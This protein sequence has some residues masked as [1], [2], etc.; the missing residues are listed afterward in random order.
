MA[1]SRYEH[2]Q[3]MHLRILSAYS[4][5]PGASFILLIPR[6]LFRRFFDLL[7][8]QTAVV[9]ILVARCSFKTLI[10]CLDLEVLATQQANTVV[11]RLSAS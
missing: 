5:V 9:N 1:L 4:R 2:K 11:S 3:P 10:I 7:P 6:W 8:V